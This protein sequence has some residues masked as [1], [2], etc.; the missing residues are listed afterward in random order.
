MANLAIKI[1]VGNSGLEYVCGKEYL[2]SPDHR[3]DTKINPQAVLDKI[4]FILREH[5]EYFPDKKECE[6]TIETIQSRS[7]VLC[8]QKRAIDEEQ[9]KLD[10]TL[11][12]LVMSDLDIINEAPW[13]KDN[14][15]SL[16]LKSRKSLHTRLSE[17]LCKDHHCNL[18]GDACTIYFG[19]S[20]IT[21]MFRDHDAFNDF[22][23]K[24]NVKFET[25][26]IKDRIKNLELS[27]ERDTKDLYAAKQL[28]S[29][30][31]KEKDK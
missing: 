23:L 28:L 19:D 9:V 18:D 6:V 24:H 1:M 4:E 13:I 29:N 7:K 10:N 21:L 16:S 12:K 8:D 31:A 3:E 22:T 27:I 5:F 2:F 25:K 15:F 20:E 17:L 14:K 30:I 11:V 26:Y